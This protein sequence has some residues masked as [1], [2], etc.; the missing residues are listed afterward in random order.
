MAATYLGPTLLH[1]FNGCVGGRPRGV[2]EKLWL[3]VTKEHAGGGDAGEAPALMAGATCQT[4]WGC[5]VGLQSL[6][7]QGTVC[8]RELVR[9]L[10]ML[11]AE[12]PGTVIGL[13]SRAA[14]GLSLA[15]GNAAAETQ[16]RCRR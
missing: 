2:G 10:P 7:L 12:T 3:Q 11:T 9:N 8:R 15:G 6:P 5:E 16:V 1:G 13:V 4:S 14:A